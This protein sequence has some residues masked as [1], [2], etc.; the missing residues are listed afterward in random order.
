MESAYAAFDISCAGLAIVFVAIGL[1]AAALIEARDL[2][3]GAG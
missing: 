2:V 1:V 3:I